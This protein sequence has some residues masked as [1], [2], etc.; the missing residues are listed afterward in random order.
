M[1]MANEQQFKTHTQ[2][3]A[4]RGVKEYRATIPALVQPQDCVLELGCA[5]GSTTR[6]LAQHSAYVLGADIS[7]DCIARAQELNPDLAFQVLDAF[8]IRSILDLR[9]PF[10]KIYLDLSGIS[11]YRALLD[12]IA[13]LSTYAAVLQPQIIVVKSGALK[14]FARHCHAW[15]GSAEMTGVKLTTV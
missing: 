8:D 12:G 2:F 10:T 13:L 11:G 1:I 6:I 5:W 7:A 15:T 9:Q 3:I 14:Q 4:T